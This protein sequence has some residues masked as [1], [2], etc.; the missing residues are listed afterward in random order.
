VKTLKIKFTIGEL[1]LIMDT[2]VEGIPKSSF[3]AIPFIEEIKRSL[4]SELQRDVNIFDSKGDPVM[5]TD[6]SSLSQNGMIKVPSLEISVDRNSRD[7]TGRRMSLGSSIGR[8][9]GRSLHD[10]LTNKR[11]Q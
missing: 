11:N 2:E 5:S 1:L 10:S 4:E 8:S 6:L 9:I 7:M 3:E